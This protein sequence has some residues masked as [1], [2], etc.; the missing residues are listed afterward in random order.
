MN[1][2]SCS[3]YQVGSLHS[4]SWLTFWAKQLHFVRNCRH[5]S[6]FSCTGLEAMRRWVLLGHQWWTF[7]RQRVWIPVLKMFFL[8][9][10]WDLVDISRFACWLLNLTP[11]SVFCLMKK[12]LISFCLPRSLV[13]WTWLR[14]FSSLHK[15]KDCLLGIIFWQSLLRTCKVDFLCLRPSI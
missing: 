12:F 2:F 7:L 15:L 8:C 9:P 3:N 6:W 13:T 14:V 4:S 5:E 10:L 11:D 1:H